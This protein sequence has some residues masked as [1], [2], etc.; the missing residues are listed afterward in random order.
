MTPPLDGI[1]VL[2][3]SR[4]LPGPACTWYL[5]GMGASVDRVEPPGAGDFARHIPP[6]VDGSGAY[7]SATS[8]G[9]RSLAV[10]LRHPEGPALIRS[11]LGAYDVLVEGFKPGVMEAMGLDPTA[12]LQ[13]FPGLVIA[14]I[15]GFGQTGPWAERPGHDLNYVGITGV[16]SLAPQPSGRPAVPSTQVADFTGALVAAM[17]ISAALFARERT[18]QGRV[19]DISLA[20]A[21]LSTMGP[22]VASHQDRAPEPGGE[23]LTGGLPIYGVYRCADGRFLTVGALEPKFQQQLAEHTSSLSEPALEALFATRARDEWVEILK[24]ACVGEALGFDEL[25]AHPQHAAR[26]SV[27]RARGTTWVVPPLAPHTAPGPVPALGEHSTE[28]LLD[29]G[30][31]QEDVDGLIHRGVVT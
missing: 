7:F 24:D 28:V 31:S 4:L 30:L 20:E 6:F 21:A 27:V 26:G 22:A 14:R 3:L 15:S 10:N 16:L 9:K 12:L 1:R 13:E 5:Q 11:M 19:L 23:V 8:T 17:G 2:D 25:A 29:A 18:G